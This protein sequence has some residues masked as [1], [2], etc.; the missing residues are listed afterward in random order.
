MRWRDEAC[1]PELERVAA[2]LLLV[3]AAEIGGWAVGAAVECWNGWDEG[4]CG[5]VR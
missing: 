5:V 4:E 1:F 2:F 3:L